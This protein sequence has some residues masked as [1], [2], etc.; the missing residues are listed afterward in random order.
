MRII[1]IDP[2]YAI[3]GW[4][5]L[6]QKKDKIKLVDYGAVEIKEKDFYKRVFQIANNL[7]KIVYKYKPVQASIEKLFFYKNIKT[8][9]DVAQVR[10]AISLMFLQNNVKIYDYTPLQIK[11]AVTGYGRATK[12]QI[13]KMIKTL[14][15]MDKILQPDDVADAAAIG[16]CHLNSINFYKAV[17]G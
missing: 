9:V 17:E 12:Q 6:D 14:L 15:N 4:A 13:Q 7:E 1:G 3:T 8:A 11:Q 10:G 16:I 5:I 2:G